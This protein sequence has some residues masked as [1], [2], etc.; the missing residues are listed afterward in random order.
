MGLDFEV[1][2]SITPATLLS[3]GEYMYPHQPFAIGANTSK[4]PWNDFPEFKDIDFSA[5]NRTSPAVSP[6]ATSESSCSCLAQAVS[7][8]EAIEVAA[9]GQ[10]ELSSDAS[11]ILQHQKKALIECEELLECRKYNTQPA[12]VMLLLSMCSKILGTLEDIG[13][14]EEVTNAEQSSEKRKRKKYGSNVGDGDES[15]PRGHG[16]NIRKLHLDDDDEHI[17]LQSLLTARVARLDRLLS[18]L[19]KVISKHSWP[20][21][22]S[23]IRELQNRVTGGSFVVEMIW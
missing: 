13:R 21:H 22:K 9:W 14:G 15:R 1:S 5:G 18:M 4:S 2:D 11:D 23:L 12:Y 8:Y 16:I 10:K 3:D 17:V 19:D 20:A 6:L 7:T